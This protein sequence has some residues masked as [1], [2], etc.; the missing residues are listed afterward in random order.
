MTNLISEMVKGVLNAKLRLIRVS[1]T[2]AQQSGL[3]VDPINVNET[4]EFKFI[5]LKQTPLI[6]FVFASFSTTSQSE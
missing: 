5:A 6:C 3:R 1:T 4:A 2:H